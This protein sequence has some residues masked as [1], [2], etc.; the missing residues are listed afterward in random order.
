MVFLD[1]FFLF[2]IFVPLMLIWGFSAYDIFTRPDLSG[3]KRVGWFLAIFLLP[4]L[5]TLVYLGFRPSAV[6]PGEKR[7]EA[8]AQAA[9]FESLNAEQLERVSLMHDQ[10]KLND[11]EY[12]IAK[13]K[14][15]T[16]T[17]PKPELRAS[18]PP[19]EPPHS[20]H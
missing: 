18:R 8:A 9:Y 6:T 3:G 16:S 5:G 20:T 1:W 10:G 13:A 4:V 2:L 19:E 17:A 7:A 11:Q 12:A 14:L 15:L